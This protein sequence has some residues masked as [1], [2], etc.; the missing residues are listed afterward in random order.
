MMEILWLKKKVISLCAA[1]DAETH[2]SM[3]YELLIIGMC[4]L[5]KPITDHTELQSRLVL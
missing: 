4:C 3:D 1:S 2:A 5:P